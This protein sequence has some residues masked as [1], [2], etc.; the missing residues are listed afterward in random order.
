MVVTTYKGNNRWVA[1][2]THFDS[3]DSFFLIPWC[4]WTKEKLKSRTPFS[5]SH[6]VP[7]WGMVKRCQHGSFFVLCTQEEASW[8]QVLEIHGHTSRWRAENRTGKEHKLLRTSPWGDVF[9]GENQS[10]ARSTEISEMAQLHPLVMKKNNWA[11]RGGDLVSSH[12][13]WGVLAGVYL[14]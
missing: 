11:Q 12:S 8:P 4:S 3:T 5:V 9:S 6:E 2:F 13:R 1:F 10:I 14:S 7:V